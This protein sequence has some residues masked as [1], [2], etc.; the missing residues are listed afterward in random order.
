[1]RDAGMPAPGRLA[2]LVALDSGAADLSGKQGDT[3]LDSFIFAGDDA[4]GD[5][6]CGRRADMSSKGGR[7]V[8]R[9]EIS[10][11]YIRTLSGLKDAL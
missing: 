2:D 11:R 7:H 9:D 1:M 6:S 8:R 3:I 4:D 5:G 10:R